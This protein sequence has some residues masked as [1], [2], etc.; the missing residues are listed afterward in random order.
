MT[1]RSRKTRSSSHR[2]LRP[3]GAQPDDYLEAFLDLFPPRVVQRIARESDFVQRHRKLD[4]V[5]FLYTLAFETGPQLSRTLEALRDAYNKRTPDPILSAGGFYERFTP[6]RVEF[7]RQCVAYGLTRLRAAPGNRLTPKLARFTDLLIQ[8]STVIRLFAALAK[9]Y[10]PTRLAKNTKSKRTAGVK[11]ATLFSARANG[12]ARLEL[13]PESTSDIDTLKIGPWVRGSI[14]L[15]DLG[16]Y[17]HQ[18]FARIEENGGFYL[19]RLKGNAHPTLIG[20][21]LVHRGR[22]IELEG[23]RWSEVAPRLQREVLDAEVELSFQRRGYRGKRRGDTLRARLVAVWDEVHQEYHAYVTN[24]PVE[25]LPAE[26]VAELYRCRWSVELLFKEA[27]GSFHLDR[28]ATGN[29]Y[30]AES[31]IWTSWLALLV[32]RRGHSVLLERVPP[33]ERFRYP[34]IRWSRVFRDECREF[35]PPLL[36]RVGKRRVIPD[37]IDEMEGRLEVRARDP[38][39]TRERFREGWFG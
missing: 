9:F 24:V 38:N 10:P 2:R 32:S 4:P 6:Q 12:P 26:E 36:Q 21:H 39:I 25:A 27:K 33:E 23:K 37:P 14:V 17:K 20:S 35:L 31:L 34:P 18:G 5:A 22:A 1:H 29:R 30:A 3:R 19:S 16:F 13:F 28:V 8:D 7:L 15:T 11:V